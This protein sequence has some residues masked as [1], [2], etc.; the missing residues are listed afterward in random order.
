MPTEHQLLIFWLQL[1][2][3][4]FAARVLGGANS[5]ASSWSQK[6]SS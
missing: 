4:L 2:A 1:L 5:S 6:I 3:L